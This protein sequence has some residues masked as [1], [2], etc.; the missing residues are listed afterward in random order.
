MCLSQNGWI[1]DLF[2]GYEVDGFA[3]APQSGSFWEKSRFPRVE[4]LRSLIAYGYITD[5][6]DGR[7]CGR[8]RPRKGVA[9]R[10]TELGRF[11]LEY[12]E[13]ESELLCRCEAQ[14]HERQREATN[15]S[16]AAFE[17]LARRFC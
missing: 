12:D 6:G 4:K 14:F 9:F 5:C 17:K 10:A 15:S 13:T 8:C 2:V 1:F 16:R 7:S 3:H 11:E